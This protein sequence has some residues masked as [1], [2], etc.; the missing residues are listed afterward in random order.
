[1][2]KYS[3]KLQETIKENN[4][5]YITY[6]QLALILNIDILT[7]QNNIK[8]HINKLDIKGYSIEK[9]PKD[10]RRKIIKLEF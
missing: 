1:M 4:S 6:S 5:N 7:L 3:E 10:L 8:K 9:D 2:N